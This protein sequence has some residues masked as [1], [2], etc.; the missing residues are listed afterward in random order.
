VSFMLIISEFMKSKIIKEIVRIKDP[1]ETNWINWR[2][3]EHRASWF[4]IKGFVN[5]LITIRYN[6]AEK[7]RIDFFQ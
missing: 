4:R 3:S 6:A 2:M 1:T 5:E 7:R